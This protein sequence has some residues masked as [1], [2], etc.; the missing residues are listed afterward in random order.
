MNIIKKEN[1]NISDQ[2]VSFW[3]KHR[4]IDFSSSQAINFFFQLQIVL[5]HLFELT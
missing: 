4:K 2:N 5:N 1:K 3:C